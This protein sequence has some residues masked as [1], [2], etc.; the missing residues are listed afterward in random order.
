MPR[1]EAKKAAKEN[2]K[3]VDEATAGKTIRGIL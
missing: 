1:K 3:V 2:K